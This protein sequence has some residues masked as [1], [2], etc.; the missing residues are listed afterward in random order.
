MADPPTD[1]LATSM[2]LN[3]SKRAAKSS[4]RALTLSPQTSTDFSSNDFLTLSSSPTLHASFLSHLSSSPPRLGSGG[5]R[6]LDGNSTYA[7][8]LESDIA[9]F[10][11]AE[12]GC[13]FNAGFDANAGFFACVPQPG[14]V[15]V[16]DAAI[17]ASV[18]E[19][20]RLSRAGARL[21]F[22]HNDVDDLQRVLEGV[23]AKDELVRTGKRSVFLAVESL[24][25]MDGDVAPLT[26]IVEAVE[27]LLPRGNGKII[28]DEAHST[29]LY[30]EHGRGVVCSL[31]L[32]RRVFARLHTFGKALA[33]NG[34]IMLCSP[35]TREYMINYARPLIYT[36]FMSYPSLVAIRTVYDLMIDGGTVAVRFPPTFVPP[37]LTP[38]Q[39]A[40]H[41]W[42]LVSHLHARLLALSLPPSNRLLRI[43]HLCPE[44]PIFSLLTPRPRD[45]AKECQAAGFMVR[46][47]VA[48]TVPVGG[49]RPAEEAG[50]GM[51]Q[52]SSQE[53]NIGEKSGLVSIGSHCLYMAVSGPDR[54]EGEL[55]VVLMTGLGST[56]DEW[57]AVRRLVE[58]F[59]RFLCYDRSGLGKSEG[60]PTTPKAIS[61]VSVATE[62]DTLLKNTGVSPPYVILCHSRG[63]ITA[64]EFLHLRPNDVAGMVFV[65]ANQE[66]TFLHHE[67]FPSPSFELMLAGVDYYEVTGIKANTALSKEEFQAV[68]DV[69]GK[70]STGITSL[71]EEVGAK[72]DPPVLAAKKQL[73]N[74][75]LGNRPVSVIHANTA[76]DFQRLYEAGIKAGNG[77]ERDRQEFRDIV[78]FWR[79][80]S[81]MRAKEILDLSSVHNF[82]DASNSGHNIQL[83]EP[84]LI[85]EE[86]KWVYSHLA[87]RA[88]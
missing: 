44:S 60:P 52:E 37:L 33:C 69:Q 48:P 38:I 29:G 7:E 17:H 83:L 39:P 50:S 32:E 81:A 8:T 24:Y 56:I 64:R 87:K 78:E 1:A 68:L 4:L 40:A 75:A 77:S 53:W 2:R 73:Q 47:I 41:M 61:A 84:E 11:G 14:D 70:P 5:S 76:R 42:A 58:P 20:M 62:L 46:A 55:I 25:S 31:G 80:T 72:G 27:R 45:L 23:L 88:D 30:G 35:L 21:P 59:S 16:H 22:R 15:V 13:L 57:V 85:V 49:E 79:D 26:A 6:L 12:A 10:H 18:H 65:D 82:R 19:G 74:Q 67:D 43:P 9:S 51:A 86:V 34:A 36:T 3:L 71:A 66:N 63:G 28:V 54:Q